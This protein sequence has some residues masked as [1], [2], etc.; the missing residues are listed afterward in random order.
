RLLTRDGTFLTFAGGAGASGLPVE[1]AGV[2]TPSGGVSDSLGNLYVADSGH[3]R[4]MRV[5][6][7]GLVDVF[8][9]RG[10]PG[11]A[12][13][14]GLAE[15]AGFGSAELRSTVLS[16]LAIDAQG[17]LYVADALN[18]RIRRISPLGIITT[19]AGTGVMGFSGDNGPAAAAQVGDLRK[20]AVDA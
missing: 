18:Y 2:V 5:S 15:Q 19:A 12:G 16:S 11:F 3:H 7:A 4:I 1:R 14:N 20:M 9:G 10:A 8:A 6:I 17:N 13:D